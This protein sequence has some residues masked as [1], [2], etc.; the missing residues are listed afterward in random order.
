MYVF[1]LGRVVWTTADLG[2]VFGTGQNGLVLLFM[3][4]DRYV[5]EIML[6]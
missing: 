3:S 5:Y 2:E 6:R 1:D 4:S